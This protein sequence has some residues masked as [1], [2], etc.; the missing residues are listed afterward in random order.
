MREGVVPARQSIDMN[1]NSNRDYERSGAL[2]G[3]ILFE[4][5]L[6]A[7][8]TFS[9]GKESR[10]DGGWRISSSQESYRKYKE[11]GITKFKGQ[12]LRRE[13]R[14]VRFGESLSMSL[15]KGKRRGLLEGEGLVRRGRGVEWVSYGGEVL[16]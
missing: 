16:N 14:V 10:G 13:R 2:E 15:R 8:L 11:D 6:E 1:V 7:A 12:Y 9:R 5:S 4:F 3:E